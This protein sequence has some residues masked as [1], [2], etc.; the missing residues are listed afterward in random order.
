MLGEFG[1]ADPG[2]TEEQERSGGAVR[3]GD[4][5][6]G[7]ADRIRDGLHGLGLTDHTVADLVFHPQELLGFTFEHAA[8]GDARP[9][10]DDLCDVV[11]ADFLLEH[12][13]AIG[14]GARRLRCGLELLLQFG[15]AAVAQLRGLTEVAVAFGAFLFTAQRFELF[16]DLSDGVDR[17]LLVLP[18]RGELVELLAFVGKFAAQFLEP[19]LRRSVGFLLQCHLLDFEATDDAFDGVDLLGSRVDLHP[20]PRRGLVDEVDGLVGEE[21]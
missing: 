6:T 7:T 20:Q 9:C 18:T 13:I 21:P 10:C 1:L 5:G 14:C 4:T 3:V 11:R 8:G 15:D 19:F 12:H 2:G 16:L 17:G